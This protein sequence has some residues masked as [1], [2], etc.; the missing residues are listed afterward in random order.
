MGEGRKKGNDAHGYILL[1]EN[2]SLTLVF[3]F[4]VEVRFPIPGPL[5]YFG[6]AS[7]FWEGTL[8]AS[9]P[10]LRGAA[11]TSAGHVLTRQGPSPGPRE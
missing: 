8:F 2:L 7:L 10:S 11:P 4:L 1:L 5:I 9:P 6:G 3:E